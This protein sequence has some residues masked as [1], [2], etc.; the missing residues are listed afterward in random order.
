MPD[1]SPSDWRELVARLTAIRDAPGETLE[2]RQAATD[3]LAKIA[4]N[5][6][7]VAA[8]AEPDPRPWINPEKWI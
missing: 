2:R 4:R 8:L 6:E 3:I 1:H 7:A 5:P